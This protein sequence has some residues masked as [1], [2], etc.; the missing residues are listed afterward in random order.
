[1]KPSISAI[2]YLIFFAVIAITGCSSGS[3]GIP[4]MDASNTETSIDTSQNDIG[5]S[6]IENQKVD[7][8]VFYTQA[9]GDYIRLVKEKYQIT[10]DT[11]FFGKHVFG[12]PDD[13]PDIEL[14]TVIG[15]TAI[16]LISPEE[17]EAIQKKQRSSFYINLFRWETSTTTE[18]VFITFSDGFAH[19][20]DCYVTYK[21]AINSKGY[22]LE[23]SRFENFQ[24]NRG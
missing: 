21:N 11:L 23:R 17:G 5:K 10:F 12:Q 9:I 24:Y 19:Q 14:P 7:L 6:E 13:F 15:K 20:F 22:V 1:M 16:R 18:F 4:N 2:A 8:A 3:T